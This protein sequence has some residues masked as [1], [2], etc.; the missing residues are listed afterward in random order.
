MD[1]LDAFVAALDRTDAALERPREDDL[2]PDEDAYDYKYEVDPDEHTPESAE[3]AADQG[4]AH[5]RPQGGEM[6]EP[7]SPRPEDE[8]A[9]DDPEDADRLERSAQT[10]GNI[11]DRLG[12]K[13]SLRDLWR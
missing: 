4:R 11:Y 7:T 12:P 5:G 10:I 13:A 3:R 9:E 2:G 8:E 1:I 6:S